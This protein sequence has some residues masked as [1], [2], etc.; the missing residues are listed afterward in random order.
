[1]DDGVVYKSTSLNIIARQI[2]LKFT[3][4]KT[5]KKKHN[6]QSI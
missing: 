4:K 3:K 6:T 2:Y 1:M 5:N